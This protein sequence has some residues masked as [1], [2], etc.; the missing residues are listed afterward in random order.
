PT[1]VKRFRQVE[2][3]NASH[4]DPFSIG[5]NDA[6]RASHP[7]SIWTDYQ[8]PLF[9]FHGCCQRGLT[10]ATQF[11]FRCQPLELRVVVYATHYTSILRTRSHRMHFGKNPFALL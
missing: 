9:W 2:T 6:T 1:V 8:S 10:T 5:R 7:I 4:P 11:I 3:K